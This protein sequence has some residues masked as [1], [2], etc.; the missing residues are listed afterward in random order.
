MKECA[1]LRVSMKI[2]GVSIFS[3]MMNVL[4]TYLLQRREFTLSLKVF[5]NAGHEY[6]YG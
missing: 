5:F 4:S 6:I 3:M 2:D 1:L